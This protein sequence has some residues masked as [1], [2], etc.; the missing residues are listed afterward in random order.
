M[1]VHPRNIQETLVNGVIVYRSVSGLDFL[2]VKRLFASAGA[3]EL[4]CD[5]IIEVL[6]DGHTEERRDNGTASKGDAG[7]KDNLER[8][9]VGGLGGLGDSGCDLVGDSG[10]G[11]HG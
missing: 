3:M 9:G 10:D 8:V 5:D 11:L 2:G 6:V 4:G 7:Q 1:Q